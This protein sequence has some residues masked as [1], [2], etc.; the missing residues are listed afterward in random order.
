MSFQ[1]ALAPNPSLH[2]FRDGIALDC[3]R[4]AENLDEFG[5]AGNIALNALYVMV[6]LG[7]ARKLK[8]K[9]GKAMLFRVK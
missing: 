6:A 3:R 7:R 1:I 8:K 9:L 4:V 5:A 2:C